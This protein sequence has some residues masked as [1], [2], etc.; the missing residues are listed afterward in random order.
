MLFGD[1]N[2]LL[3]LWITPIVAALMALSER[4]RRL[5]LRRFAATTLLPKISEGSRPVAR[6]LKATMVLL[7]LTL[8]TLALARPLGEPMPAPIVRSG[9]DVIFM[10]DVSRSMRAEDLAPNRLE[11]AK[12]MID[13]AIK[14]MTGQ[15]VALVAFAG[16]TVIKSPPTNDYGFVRMML[17]DLSTDSVSRGG[18][19]IGDAI[20]KILADLLPAE[21][22]GRMRDI[23]LITD[24]EDHDSFP[25]E[26]AQQA[27]KR[28]VRLIVIGLGDAE[29]GTPIP[30]VD[31][32]GRRT[33]LQYQGA[34]V[35]SQLEETQLRQIA[36]ASPRG[37]YLPV[38]T[39]TIDLAAVYQ[40][41]SRDRMRQEV[42]ESETT[43][44]RELF[45]WF[46][47]AACALL[48][49]EGLIS[50]RRRRAT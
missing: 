37:V 20:R 21:D 38:R 4:R 6:L 19:L 9:Q 41:L 22:D 26:A 16:T 11:R 47:G 43:R 8:T 50:E 3:A 49:C 33:F 25:V 44:R 18:S 15:R 39:G 46:L 5:A 45:Q 10:L 7:A 29:T 34:T 14:S 2:W 13:D 42:E 1:S 36:A 12:L 35:R 40:D 27:A 31:E 17:N 32:R 28:G 48:V 24:G 30:V 23:I